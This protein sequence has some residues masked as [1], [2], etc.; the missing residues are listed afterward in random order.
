MEYS[1]VTFVYSELAG[2]YTRIVRLKWDYTSPALFQARM[3]RVKHRA[4]ITPG[5]SSSYQQKRRE[6]QQVMLGEATS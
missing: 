2:D 4:K 6:E 3:R 5:N 1:K